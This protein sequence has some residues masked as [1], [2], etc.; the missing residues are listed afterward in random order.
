MSGVSDSCF[1]N[2][3]DHYLQLTE[4]E[5]LDLLVLEESP[6]V[7]EAGTVLYAEDKDEADA[8][9]IVQSGRLHAST[10]LADGGRALLKLH[11]AGDI[12]GT[13]NIPFTT[14]ISTVTVVREARLCRFPRSSLTTLFEVHP[15]LAAL[16][17]SVG[18]L[19]NVSLTDRLRSIGRTDGLSRIGSLLL[20]ITSRLRV[21]NKDFGNEVELHMTQAD[22]GD[23][24]GLT[25]VHVN[26]ML[27]ELADQGLIERTGST[28]TI[29]DEDRLREVA[30]FT[31]RYHRIETDWFPAAKE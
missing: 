9:Y 5:K 4:R 20:E 1:I 16:F 12:V 21:T 15:R 25:H 2:K 17:Y 30:H 31:E 22:I 11:F 3:L 6:Q 26:R 29:L 8:L 7:Y 19:E 23:A 13:S 18:M 14:A 24:V 27:R 10:V 28:V